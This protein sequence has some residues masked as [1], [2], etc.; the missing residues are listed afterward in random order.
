M[1][2]VKYIFRIIIWTVPLG[3]LGVLW[4][5]QSED[6]FFLLINTVLYGIS[7]LQQYILLLNFFPVNL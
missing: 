4:G 2:N 5:P 3:K 7:F 6:T 1:D